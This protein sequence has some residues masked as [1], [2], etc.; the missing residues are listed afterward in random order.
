M[1][2]TSG[3]KRDPNSL[4]PT[5][6][7]A[8]DGFPS[9]VMTA[10]RLRDGSLLFRPE[11][12]T[13]SPRKLESNPLTVPRTDLRAVHRRWRATGFEFVVE[14]DERLGPGGRTVHPARRLECSSDPVPAL[15]G[16]DAMRC[17]RWELRPNTQHAIGLFNAVVSG[18]RFAATPFPIRSSS[19]I[20]RLLV[21]RLTAIQGGLVV[22]R[23]SRR[24]AA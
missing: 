23:R 22:E 15:P 21:D 12:T 24:C 9:D 18:K 3:C 5:R 13:R 20:W 11:R 16:A 14:R 4:S 2:S 1:S 6:V 19:T 10:C 8:A 7:D 17:L